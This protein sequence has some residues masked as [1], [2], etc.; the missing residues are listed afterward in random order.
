[1]D[2]MI[3][4]RDDDFLKKNNRKVKQIGRQENTGKQDYMAYTGT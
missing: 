3:M 2:I 4:R 1:M